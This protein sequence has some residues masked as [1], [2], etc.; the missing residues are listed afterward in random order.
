M[1]ATL[2]DNRLVRIRAI[3]PHDKPELAAALAALSPES[4]H[5]RFLSAKPSFSEAELRYL[6]E[7]DGW[8]H[9]AL[10][11]SPVEDPEAIVGVARFV[12]DRERADTAEF[13]IVVDDA[14]QGLGLATRLAEALVA[15]ALVRG[16]TRFTATTL[17]DNH[18][19]QRVIAS[20]AETLEHVGHEGATTLLVAEL[21]A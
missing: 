18:A 2:K 3:R 15:R 10:V 12:R 21:A 1:L 17:S 6:T 8:D 16:V 20:I 4:Q 11:A 9:V 7:V 19:V 13:A 14:W 5:S